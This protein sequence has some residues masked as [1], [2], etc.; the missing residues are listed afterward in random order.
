MRIWTAYRYLT[1]PSRWR[2]CGALRQNSLPL[3]QNSPK[4]HLRTVKIR[5]LTRMS[6]TQCNILALPFMYLTRILTP[7]VTS[8]LQVGEAEPARGHL[9]C[10]ERFTLQA[11][12]RMVRCT[13]HSFSLGSGPILICLLTAGTDRWGCGWERDPTLWQ[14][15]R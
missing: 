3:W 2:K 14:V 13:S 8:V 6:L 10:K 4:M 12:P 11:N 5:C 1:H 7:V 15:Y 9:Y